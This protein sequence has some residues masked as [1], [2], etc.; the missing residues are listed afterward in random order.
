MLLYIFMYIFEMWS[1]KSNLETQ[2][3]VSFFTSGISVFIPEGAVPKGYSEEMYITYNRET[4]DKP[5][6]SSK[7]NNADPDNYL[8]AGQYDVGEAHDSDLG[9]LCGTDKQ[10]T[11]NTQ[12]I[13]ARGSQGQVERGRLVY[14]SLFNGVSIFLFLYYH[15]FV[16]L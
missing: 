6:L 10:A 4:M 15:I 2:F 12:S 11:G 14:L 1:S 8:R 3:P 13:I 16:C 5:K 9:T 7:Q